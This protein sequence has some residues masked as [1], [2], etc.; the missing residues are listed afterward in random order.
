MPSTSTG[1]V[2]VISDPTPSTSTAATLAA[3]TSST[4]PLARLGSVSV[5]SM[6]RIN[7]RSRSLSVS[8][9][10][11]SSSS[12]MS[13][14][15]TGFAKC[16]DHRGKAPTVSEGDLTPEV[17]KQFVDYSTNFFIAKS[18]FD[19]EGPLVVRQQ[20]R[21]VYTAF[22]DDCVRDWITTDRDKHLAMTFDEFVVALRT[23]FLPVDWED[24]LRIRIMSAIFD[25]TRETFWVFANRLQKLNS[26]LRETP[27]HFKPAALREQLEA[28]MD[29]P[30]RQKYIEEKLRDV[31]NFNKWLDARE[32][33]DKV[34]R[35][36]KRPLTNSS[37]ANTTSSLSSNTSSSNSRSQSSS[38][39]NRP[40][41]LTAD[42]RALLLA[43]K[44]CFKCRMPFA[45]HFSC[46]CTKDYPNAATYQ[47]ITQARI[48]QFKAARARSSKPAAKS[49]SSSTVAAVTSSL[50]SPSW[51]V[52]TAGAAQSI[53]AVLP[54]SLIATVYHS[55]EDEPDD[56]EVSL[57]PLS[58]LHLRWECTM[59]GPGVPEPI[60]VSSL[61]D[62][63]SHLVLIEE[64]LVD[65]LC[66]RRFC[67]HEPFEVAVAL[68]NDSKRTTH[69]SEY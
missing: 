21:N 16:K 19:S 25:P 26:L 7:K 4:V 44:G 22:K 8:S 41:P 52:T 68:D 42:E 30:L 65:R 62:D 10:D 12:A 66:L 58:V 3:A 43:N 27:S 1:P 2:S 59:A 46:T 40:P 11:S 36:T 31:L 63:G 49:S 67:L 48:D 24:T 9:D 33:A 47:P 69:L 45:G 37:R 23:N 39:S 28:K 35:A 15:N 50:T 17:I 57:A 60:A 34:M 55:D 5:L 14:T 32:I 29:A 51:E 61:L 64:S 6:L 53:A 18:I 20:V 56:V 13:P 54:A 38:S